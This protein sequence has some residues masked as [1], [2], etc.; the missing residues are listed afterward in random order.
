MSPVEILPSVKKIDGVVTI[1]GET[2]A[3][4]HVLLRDYA[5]RIIRRCAP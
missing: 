4:L 2:W 3:A 1:P 5:D